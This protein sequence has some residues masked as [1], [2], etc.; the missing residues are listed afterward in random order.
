[1]TSPY[2]YVTAENFTKVKAI[3]D[4]GISESRTP[5]EI[6]SRLHDEVAFPLVAAQAFVSEELIG[7]ME[8]LKDAN[9]TTS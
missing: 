6:A 7:A 9:K 3:L 1:M 5:N 8:Y 2:E 4:W